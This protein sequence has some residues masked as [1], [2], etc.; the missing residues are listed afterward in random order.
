MIIKAVF[1][2]LKR[3]NRKKRKAV[4]LLHFLL[5]FPFLKNSKLPNYVYSNV[6]FFGYSRITLGKNNAFNKYVTIRAQAFESVNEL[7]EIGDGN[8]FERYSIICAHKGFI[9][10]GNDNFVG[11]KVQIQGRGGVDIGNHCL[12]AA[13]TF[14]SSSNHDFSDPESSEYLRSEV[15]NRT[16]LEDYVWVGANS[17]IVAGVRVGHHSVVGAG[18]VVTRN[19]D[20]YTMVAGNPARVIKKFNMISKCWERV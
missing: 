4:A 7:I 8:K 9:K 16:V 13:N 14:V 18:S 6:D 20:K 3:L 10:I 1:E 19:V 5:L 17:V 11:E 12:I 15:P 2:K